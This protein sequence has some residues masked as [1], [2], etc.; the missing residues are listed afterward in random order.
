MTATHNAPRPT[1]GRLGV[2]VDMRYY[3]DSTGAVWTDDP[4]VRF[5]QA[6]GPHCEHITLIGRVAPWSA[7]AGAVYRADIEG[8]TV[9]PL[10]DYPRIERLATKPWRYWPAIDRALQEQ[11]PQLDTLWLNFAHPVSLRALQL[12][13]ESPNLR[14]FAVLRGHYDRDAKFRAGDNRLKRAVAG[15][16]ASNLMDMFAKKAVERDVPCVGFGT[17]PRLEEYGLRHLP[18]MSSLLSADDVDGAI[19]DGASPTDL[20]VVGRL[21]REKGVDILLD[22]VAR[23]PDVTLRVVG[24]GE[25]R[26]ALE[27]QASELGVQERVVFDGAVPFG[28]Q[29]FDRFRAARLVVIPSRTEG[30][31]KAAYEAMAFGKPVIAAAVGGLPEIVGNDETRG[32]LAAPG[33]AC[34][35]AEQIDRALSEPG[36]IDARVQ[37]VRGVGGGITMQGQVGRIVDFLTREFAH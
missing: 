31:P 10:P 7:E 35:L 18:M 29:L 22:A 21:A 24:D 28:P 32:L 23:L 5:L 19:G 15:L 3:R 12:C 1:L 9:V 33:D 6:F 2:L 26:D 36:W 14:P 4:M 30:A 13:A 17:G 16:V 20:L 34:A 11:L 25:E 8:V 27:A 37:T